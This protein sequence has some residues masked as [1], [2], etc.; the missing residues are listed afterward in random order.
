LSSKEA[1]PAEDSSKCQ[2]CV[3]PNKFYMIV[4]GSVKTGGCKASVSADE[5]KALLDS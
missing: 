3:S 2:A 5:Q 1:E 4:N